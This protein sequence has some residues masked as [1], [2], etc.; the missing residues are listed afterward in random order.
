MGPVVNVMDQTPMSMLAARLE[1]NDKGGV[2]P[3]VANALAIL[4]YD[5]LV[6]G[7][8]GYNEF[9]EEPQLLRAPPA[10]NPNDA[11]APGPYPRA[12]RAADIVAVT[13]YMQR[14]HAPRFNRQVV[15]DAIRTEAER[16]RFHPVREWLSTLRWDGV[17]RIDSWLVKAFGAP[18]T[19]YTRAVGAKFLIAAV[20]RVRKPGCNFD[21]MPVLEGG[22]GIGKSR[23]CRRLFGEDWF[24]DSMPAD[25]TSKDGNQAVL[26]VWGIEFAE[27]EQLLRHDAET[28]K[29]FLS[30]PVERF[31][32]PYERNYMKR[33]R[34][35]VF[36]GTTNATDY[37]RDTTGNRRIW[38]VPCVH[39]DEQ[40]VAQHRDQ[41]WAEAAEREAAGEVLWL[42][43]DA[44][45]EA[46]EA[47]A[48]RLVADVWAPRIRKFLGEKRAVF[49]TH[50]T[51]AEVLGDGLGFVASQ[52]TKAAEMR[53]ATVLTR[54]GMVKTRGRIERGG[55][56]LWIWRWPEAS[57]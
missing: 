5:P 32:P 7:L 54:E 14:A 55:K 56:P 35:C 24:T 52:M 39:A 53:A 18:D 3:H 2:H 8:V 9:A 38:P 51:T 45:A 13:A 41:L 25:L 47:Q 10:L 16:S 4:A 17:A 20:R 28:M 22:Q 46:V 30:R 6:A 57:E 43:E 11:P 23:C 27:I 40:W 1:L 50:V 37:L 19:P 15:E 49:A 21:C 42:E 33:G 36:I 34:E 29:A 26:S 48:D 44:H 12:V 31:R